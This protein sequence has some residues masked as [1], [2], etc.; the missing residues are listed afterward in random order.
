MHKLNGNHKIL[1]M[2]TPHQAQYIAWQLQKQTTADNV[3]AFA[4]TLV[5]A[6]IDLNPHQIDAA[7]FACKNPL[8]RGVLL[9]DEVGLGKTIEAGLV[10]AQRIAERKKHILIITPANLRKQWHQELQEKFA[11]NSVILEK[12]T[13][14]E[15]QKKGQFPFHQNQAIICSYEFAKQKA[16]ELK[17]I[18]WDLVVFD[19]AHR[20]R[21]VY[22]NNNKTAQALK[23]ALAQVSSKVLLTATPLQNS[24]LELYGLVSFIDD[25]IFGDLASFKEQF[26]GNNP[27][28]LV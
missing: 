2:F 15:Y 17:R 14:S 24:I 10:I 22:K 18:A 25:K 3:E 13:Y 16:A 6:Q 19:E 5:N 28:N 12:N 1:T 8:S 27:H 26:G 21:N 7:I 20:L 23:E 11:I 9:A 4:S